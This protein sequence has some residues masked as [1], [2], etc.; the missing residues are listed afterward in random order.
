MP[1]R[2]FIRQ[3]SLDGDAPT[4]GRPDPGGSM[5]ESRV[6]LEFRTVYRELYQPVGNY[7]L[8]RTGCTHA[9][10]DLLGDVFLAV[11]RALPG[12]RPRGIPIR[13]WVLRIANHTA[14]RW[15]RRRRCENRA[16]TARHESM[17]RG[18]AT[19]SPTDELLRADAARRALAALPMRLQ[20]VAALHYV[21]DLS[22]EEVATTLGI[23]LG[24]AKSRLARALATARATMLPEG[25]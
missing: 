15:L 24:T 4:T 14:N 20:E 23:P 7:L 22:L 12:Y 17:L 8:R 13:N 19:A 11:W 18:E 2:D 25:R 5:P 9:T 1:T 6:Q 16:L 3:M 10:E 21:A